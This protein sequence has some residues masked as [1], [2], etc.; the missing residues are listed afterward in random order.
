MI[1]A[2]VLWCVSIL[3]Y[4]W[5]NLVQGYHKLAA[6]GSFYKI[7]SNTNSTWLGGWW[8]LTKPHS[9]NCSSITWHDKESD[10][11]SAK[12]QLKNL[13]NI[14]KSEYLHGLSSYDP[15]GFTRNSAESS[16]VTNKLSDIKTTSDKNTHK[17]GGVN[18]Q[19]AIFDV[20]LRRPPMKGWVA[21]PETG[22][23]R[24]W[25]TNIAP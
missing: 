25:G 17:T 19:L 15:Y 24:H 6:S 21:S 7:N 22:L 18:F 10:G 13:W 16:L 2:I 12:I 11:N 3:H 23:C 1:L 9:W 5:K 4:V 20:D 8:S 14:R